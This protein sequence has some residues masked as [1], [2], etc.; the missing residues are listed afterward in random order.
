MNSSSP[1]FSISEAA[2]TRIVSIIERKKAEAQANH[3]VPIALRV[4]VEAGGC[5]GF[6]YRFMLVSQDDIT[7]DDTSIYRYGAR[8]VVDSVSL[9]L[10]TDA[11]LDFT[12]KLMGAHF[13]VRNPNA[14]SSCGCGTSFSIS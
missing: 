14:V 13:A 1:S 9:T 5:N 8:V 12:D 7:D 4:A 6:Q 3:S 11:E 10:L 2:A